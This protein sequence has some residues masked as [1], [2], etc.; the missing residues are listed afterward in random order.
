M[1][2]AAARKRRER[3]RKR[4]G[5]IVVRV[6]IDHVETAEALIAAG[7]L[8]PEDEDDPRAIA[9]ALERAAVAIVGRHP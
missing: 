4:A 2:P 6:E 3:Q 1:T 7:L 9:A 5:R 8:R